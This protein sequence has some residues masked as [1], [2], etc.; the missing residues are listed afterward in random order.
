M[1]EGQFGSQKT[2]YFLK[3]L[4]NKRSDK[5][6]KLNKFPKQILQNNIELRVSNFM[7]GTNHKILNQLIKAQIKFIRLW[8]LTRDK[9]KKN[10]SL[11][12]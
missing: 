4:V 11:K 2:E 6:T 8:Y 3:R 7:I 12:S 1:E 9:T 5:R 10:Q